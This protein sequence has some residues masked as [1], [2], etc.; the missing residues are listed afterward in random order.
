MSTSVSLQGLHVSYGSLPV[1]QDFS[2]TVQCGELLALL[3]P[4]GCGK[5]TVLRTI[6]GLLQP[7]KGTIFFGSETMTGVPAERRGT[8]MVFQKPLLFPHMS[9]GGERSLRTEDAWYSGGRG[10]GTHQESS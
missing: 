1:L 4:S 9:V 6:A 8:G 7:Q 2:L 5:T 10:S 3:G